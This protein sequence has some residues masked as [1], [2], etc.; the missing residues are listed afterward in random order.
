MADKIP[1]EPPLSSLHISQRQRIQV[2]QNSKPLV[3]RHCLLGRIEPGIAALVSNQ[4][5]SIGYIGF[6]DAEY[7]ELAMAYLRKPDTS[8][9]APSSTRYAYWYA[10][11]LCFFALEN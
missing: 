4:V 11:V 5:G 8:E 9:V 7:Y 3:S 10:I 1:L 2:C 6:Y